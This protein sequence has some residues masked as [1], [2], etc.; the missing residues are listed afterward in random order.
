[1]ANSLSVEKT[2]LLTWTGHL[3]EQHDLN[4]KLDKEIRLKR[5]TQTSSP[6]IRYIFS[7][8]NERHF[9]YSERKKVGDGVQLKI[10]KNDQQIWP[11]D[12]WEFSR[13][14]EDKRPHNF[15]VNVSLGDRLYFQ[16]NINEGFSFDTT[17]WNPTIKYEDGTTY[18]ASKGFSS[19]QG[20]NQ[21]Y[22]QYWNDKN[23]EDMVYDQSFKTWRMGGSPNIP[24]ITFDTQHPSEG[25]DTARVFVVPQ[26]GTIRLIGSASVIGT[27]H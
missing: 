2:K 25:S 22:Y 13:D 3:K 21:W 16:V 18:Q 20:Q 1:M 14:S 17:F 4:L 26:D 11:K 24:S 23:Y 7:S 8:T 19:T 12:G 5:V 6:L 27:P 10:L 9:L 15:T